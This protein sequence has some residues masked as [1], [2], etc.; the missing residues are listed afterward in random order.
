MRTVIIIPA[1]NEEKAITQ[2]VKGALA[3]V[4]WV[5]IADNGSTDET[6]RLAQAAGAEVTLAPKPGYGRAC[7]AGVAQAISADLYLFMDGDGAD[8][9][10]D[11]PRLLEPILNGDTDFVIGSRALGTAEPK[12]LTF[13]QKFGNWLACFLM[14]LIW[15]AEFTDLGPMRAI[16]RDAY[17]KLEMSAKTYG[18]TVQMQVRAAKAKIRTLD[19]PVNYKRRIGKSKI[20]GTVR[21]V[22]LAGF[23]ILGVIAFEAVSFAPY[24]SVVFNSSNKQRSVHG[25]RD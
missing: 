13:P 8:N 1:L 18:W 4:D 21:G 16:R 25:S 15:K 6:A 20:S 10:N 11:I 23:H 2:V 7:L 12:S 3:H 19:V 17:E 24:R 14:R 5:I 22:I 9:A